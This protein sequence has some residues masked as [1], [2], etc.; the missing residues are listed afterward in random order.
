MQDNLAKVQTPIM[1]T[2]AIRAHGV[3]SEREPI[4][5][6]TIILFHDC[7]FVHCIRIKKISWVLPFHKEICIFFTSVGLVPEVTLYINIPSIW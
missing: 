3:L 6:I 2:D 7:I 5:I 1:A 4:T